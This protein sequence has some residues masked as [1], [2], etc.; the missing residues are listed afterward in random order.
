MQ[1]IMRDHYANTKVAI[2]ESFPHFNE[3]QVTHSANVVC[4]YLKRQCFDLCEVHISRDDYLTFDCGYYA[5]TNVVACKEII[6]L[7][8]RVD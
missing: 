1:I 7:T 5:Y 2:S 3:K 4:N 8:I 6:Y